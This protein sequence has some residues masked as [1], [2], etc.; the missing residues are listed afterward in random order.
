MRAKKSPNRSPNRTSSLISPTGIIQLMTHAM[1]GAA[2]G[3]VFT[4]TLILANP[5]VA[6]LLNHGG[7][8]ADLVFVV[9]M[10]TTFAIGAALTGV[11]F[12]L[13]GDKES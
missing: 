13:D 4:F 5:A 1:M 2:L 12:I 11:V 6:E 9:T 3:L 7:S 10:V 8:A